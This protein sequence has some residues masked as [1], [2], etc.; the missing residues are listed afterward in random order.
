MTL[1][2]VA[3]ASEQPHTTS[4]NPSN[5]SK[6]EL[7][8]MVRSGQIT[9]REARELLKRGQKPGD[10]DKVSRNEGSAPA[11]S[12]RVVAGDD[13][14][15]EAEILFNDSFEGTG[16]APWSYQTADE[17]NIAVTESLPANSGKGSLKILVRKSDEWVAGGPRS[18]VLQPRQTGYLSE[19]DQVWARGYV[20]FPDD[21]ADDPTNEIFW[22]VHGNRE[23]STVP[24]LIRSVDDEIEIVGRGIT[25][26]RVKKTKGKW[27]EISTYHKFSS[28]GHGITEVFINGD[29]ITS[30]YD[31]KN[32]DTSGQQVFWIYGLYKSG[33]KK[34]DIKSLVSERL[35][36]FD[37]ITLGIKL[38]K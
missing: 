28:T 3:C 29:L 9:K 30:G 19:G 2:I 15:G 27:M 22:Q 11:A 24:F 5:P 36:Y 6:E 25:N 21:Y 1:S 10:M 32:L 34:G 17:S 8:D 16:G 26:V 12:A 31:I 7:K 35:L 4:A 13:F 37:D 18:Q 33:W 23:S 20:M 38:A 14:F